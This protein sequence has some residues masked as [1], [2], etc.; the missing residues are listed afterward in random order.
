MKNLAIWMKKNLFSTP[1][2]SVISISV[3][4]G[5]LLILGPFIQWLLIDSVLNVVKLLVLAWPL[6]LRSIN[7]FSLVSI[8]AK[9]YGV[10][11]SPLFFSSPS[12]GG[13][14]SLSAGARDYCGAG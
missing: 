4:S 11:L 9:N 14:K 10:L 2:N 12:F 6:F 8:L 5:L 7:S 1:L 13:V 3:F